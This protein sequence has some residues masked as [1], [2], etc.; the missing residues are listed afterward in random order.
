MTKETKIGLLVG[1]GFIILIGILVS[2]HL[3]EAQK[4]KPGDMR[5]DNT[6]ALTYDATPVTPEVN[7]PYQINRVET[8]DQNLPDNSVDINAG[9]YRGGGAVP[10]RI[11]DDVNEG[12]DSG[13]YEPNVITIPP[14]VPNGDE[15]PPVSGGNS[16]I[17]NSGVNDMRNHPELEVVPGPGGN[18]RKLIDDHETEKMAS[19]PVKK[20]REHH[21][22]SDETLSDISKEYYGTTKHWRLIAEY[23]RKEIPN[24]NVIRAGVR[25]IIPDLPSAKKEEVKKSPVVKEVKKEAPKAEFDSYTVK[26]GD[27]LSR[28]AARFYGKQS[29]WLKLYELNKSVIDDPDRLKPG[30]VIRVPRQ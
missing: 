17:A 3:S 2:D 1:M 14:V 10:P 20:G 23:N 18:G 11:E 12:A 6:Q 7:A 25:I 13:S 21:I 4:Q 27:V 29:A 28:L 5:W 22:R 15:L 19:E 26:S 30:T 8:L 24:P 16:G 9:V